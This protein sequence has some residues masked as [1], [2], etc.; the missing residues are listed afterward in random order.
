M[1]VMEARRIRRDFYRLTNPTEEE[2]FAFT[3]ALEY[4]ICETKDPSAMLDLGSMYYEERQFDLALKYYEMAAASGDLAAI[5]NLGYIWYYGR[6]GVKDYEKAFHYFDRARKMGDLVAAYKVADMYKNGYYVE[7]DPAKYRTIIEELYR[8]LKNEHDPF[9]PVPEVFTRLAKIRSEDGDTAEALRL[10][11]R[12]RELLSR[13]IQAHPFFGDLN[14]M[15]WMIADMD[16]L[17]PLDT[18][19][20]GLYDLYALLSAPALVRF[21]FEQTR[22]EVEAAEED[23]GIAV[24]LDERWFRSV[25]DFFLKAE[26]DGEKLTMRCEEIREWEVL[27]WTK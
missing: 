13:R 7:K 3:E 8:K 24:R 20:I 1:T 16:R 25:D 4:L 19:T 9:A 17:R 6:T 14:I 27:S 5:S 23:G 22:H 2:R 12:A 11:D 21:S 10:Y 18:K 15:K 26:L